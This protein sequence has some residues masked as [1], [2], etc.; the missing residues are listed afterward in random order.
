LRHLSGASV[1][2]LLA[3]HRHGRVQ[4]TTR[5]S[6]LFFQL[7]MQ[8]APLAYT[9]FCDNNKEMEPYR[10]WKTGFWETHLQGKPYHIS[11]LYL[12]DLVRFR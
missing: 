2:G 5:S 7:C 10:F 8:G 4:H 9:P 3:Q 6:Q 12:I 1:E 11:A